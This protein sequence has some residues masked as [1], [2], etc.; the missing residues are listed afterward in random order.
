[1]TV[2]I[3]STLLLACMITTASSPVLAEPPS[4]D[5]VSY[6]TAMRCSALSSLF[7]ATNKDK[8]NEVKFHHDIAT[9]WLTLAMVRDGKKGVRAQKEHQPL[10]ENLVQ[11]V[12]AMAD[13]QD[14]LKK[15]LEKGVTTCAEFQA[16]AAA[17]FAAVDVE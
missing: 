4:T 15:F 6:K 16:A 13:D 2:L 7:A 11:R 1:M 12:N 14:G 8:P 9:R 10:L 3:R 5:P 17:E